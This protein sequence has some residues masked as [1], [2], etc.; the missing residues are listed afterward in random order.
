MTVAI[1]K[2]RRLKSPVYTGSGFTLIETVVVILIAGVFLGLVS[3][4]SKAVDRSRLNIAALMVAEDIRLTQQLSLNQNG[5]YRIIFDYTGERYYLLKGVEAVKTVNLPA[6]VNLVK[7]NF[8]SDEL[9][10]NYR[11]IPSQGGTVTLRNK[12]GSYLYVIVTPVT[13]RVRIG[14][15]PP[16]S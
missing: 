13:G 6:G 7:T 2:D 8:P 10:F 14:T 3:I 16:Q 11:G 9:K 1:K 12:K 15:T 4:S 5:E